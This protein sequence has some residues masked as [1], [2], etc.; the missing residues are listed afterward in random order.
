MGE[1]IYTNQ[2]ISTVMNEILNE[3][4]DYYDSDYAYYVEK[5]AEEIRV[6]YEWCADGWPGKKEQI[7]M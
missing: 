4:R 2:S 5:D 6:I 3:I 7:R 1:K